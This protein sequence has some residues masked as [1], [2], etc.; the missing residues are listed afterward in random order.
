MTTGR[1]RRTSRADRRVRCR[2]E[3]YFGLRRKLNEIPDADGR[4]GHR[5]APSAD[6]TEHGDPSVSSDDVTVTDD[7][8]FSA[9]EREAM[10][11]RAH[12][13]AEGR[14]GASKVKDLQNVL[15]AIAEM[16]DFDRPLAERLHAL[17][18]RVA[19]DLY[20][21]T[22][23][24]FP[25]YGRGNRGKEIV[26]YFT[27]REKGEAR[28]ATVGFNTGATLDDGL[29]WPTSYALIGWDDQVESRLE[30]LVA[31]AAA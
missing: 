16:D 12:E 3:W 4:H 14:G 2:P 28:Y 18:L 9:A 6:T 29:M 11:T 1:R 31:R 25:A 7:S 27:S 10:K 24:G 30:E 23:Y 20:V 5:G 17:V 8:G 22:W 19:P 13:L 21:K 26:L 15:N